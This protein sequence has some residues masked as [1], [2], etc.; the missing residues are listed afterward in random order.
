MPSLH[1]LEK[2]AVKDCDSIEVLFDIDIDVGCLGENKEGCGSKLRSIKVKNLGKLTE[3]W[4]LKV[5]NINHPDDVIIY[6][7]FQAVEKIDIDGCESFRNIFKPTTAKFGLRALKHCSINSI[8]QAHNNDLKSREEIFKEALSLLQQDQKAHL[9]ALCGMGGVGKTTMMEQLK[10]AVEDKKMFDWVVKVVIG[11]KINI[12]SI[13]QTVAEYIKLQLTETDKTARADRLRITF[14]KMSQESK[15][16][17]LVVLDDVWE[18]V[19][20]KD[21]G[22]SPLP[23]GFKLLLTSQDENVCTQIAV[24]ADSDLS[25]VRVNVMEESEANNFFFQISKVSNPELKDIGAKIVR[26]C[27]FLPLAIKIIATTLKYKEKPV[28]RDTLYRLKKNELD[29]DV[30]SIIEIS[31]EFIAEEDVKEVF[32]LCGLFPDDFNIPI[33]DLTRYAWGLKLLNKVHTVG[34][35]RDR[36]KTCV[37]NLKKANLLLDSDQSECVKMHD[38][39]LAFVVA[40]VSKGD[41]PWIVNHS[42]VSNWSRAEMSESCRSISLTCMGMSEFPRDFKYPKVSLLRLMNGDESLKFPD[43]FYEKMEN[44]QVMAFEKLYYPLPP[45]SLQCSTTLR[46]LCLHKCSLM[47]DCS[48]IGDHLLNLEVLSFARS[49]IRYLPSAIGKL[50]K[51]KLL[52]LT[53]CMDLR[54]D[55][56]VLKNLV[57]LEELYMR[58]AYGNGIKFTDIN[59]KELGE[60]SKNLS[61]L[62]VEFIENNPHSKNMSYNRL[63]RFKISIGRYLERHYSVKDMHSSENTLMIKVANK[64]ELL[65][66]GTNELFTKTEVLH[67]ETGSGMKNLEEVLPKSVPRH[68]SFYNLRVLHVFQCFDLGYLFTVPVARG[69]VKLERLTIEECPVMEALVYGE[70]NGE[71]RVDIRFQGL[72]FLYL[73]DLPKLEGLCNTNNIVIHLPQLLEL[74]L[75]DLPNFTSIYPG[76]YKSA[77]A[78]SS[79]VMSAN[80]SSSAI[81]NKPFFN[82]QVLIPPRLEVLRIYQMKALKNIWPPCEEVVDDATSCCLLREIRVYHCDNLVNM[83]PRNPMPLL[84]HLETIY[85]NSCG[86]IQ[87]LFDIDVDVGEIK[88]GCGSKLRSIAVLRSIDVGCI[89]E[90]KEGARSKLRSIEVWNSGKLTEMWR[91][92]GGGVVNINHPD[93]DDDVIIC[94]CFQAVEEIH[95]FAKGIQIICSPC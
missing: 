22:L 59:Y 61:A 15:E 94:G 3:V 68:T 89:G 58:A 1:H 86:S 8:S 23:N 51:L 75:Y 67:L 48:P 9:I 10:K 74:V 14:A 91:L 77:T 19:E 7:C 80:T 73:R 84:H 60:R 12:L 21:V 54:I 92:K 37:L 63:E 71:E 87:V 93:D 46:T 26:R 13:Q 50:V 70:G 20:L 25:V 28:W 24:E 38:L 35:A 29:N 11:Q 88:Q 85:V 30:Q 95:I 90:I 33:E 4:R 49:R 41:H 47:F 66:S 52:D 82:K 57:K 34:E 79:N 39:V 64:D 65:E 81:I 45:T 72:K 5:V 56:G 83:F 78:K 36:T 27:G 44:L 43:D 62:E 40:K 2:I 69:L 32:L 6:G 55:E 17:V 53:G 76:E 31:Y 16:K 18:K 42:D